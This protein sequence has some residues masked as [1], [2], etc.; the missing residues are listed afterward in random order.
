MFKKFCENAKVVQEDDIE[1]TGTVWTY[2][3]RG[4]DKDVATD[5]ENTLYTEG[6]IKVEDLTDY[7]RQCNFLSDMAPGDWVVMGRNYSINAIGV[8]VDYSPVEI[9]DGVFHYQRSVEWKAT[10][11]SL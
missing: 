1:Y 7:K 5:Y 8:I 10:G 11:L 6:V 9:A 2:R 3:N 4:G